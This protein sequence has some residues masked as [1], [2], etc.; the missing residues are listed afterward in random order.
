M[1]IANPIYDVVFKYLMEDSKLAKLLISSIIQQDIEIIDFK[2]REFSTEIE[3]GRIS[4][5]KPN[6]SKNDLFFFTV[7][8]LD[9]SAKIKTADGEK[10][11]IIEIQKAKLATDILCFRGYLGEQYGNKENVFWAT[12]KDKKRKWACEIISIYFLGNSLENIKG[13]PVIKS[14]KTYIDVNTGEEIKQKEY[15]LDSLNHESYTIPIPELKQKRR[16]ELE[17]LLGI[18]D[19]SNRSSD[20]HI[21]NVKEEDFPVKFRE[22]IR[23]LQKAADEPEIRKKMD[24]E[25][26]IIEELAERDRELIEKDAVIDTNLKLLAEETKQKEEAIARENEAKA[27][28]E[29]ERRQ[30]EIIKRYYKGESVESLVLEYD[31]TIEEIKK[32]V[33]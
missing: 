2:P 19:Q 6:Q 30:K 20:D 12:E 7:Y 10:I 22:I 8:R 16:N 21:M 29:D 31:K 13:V 9:F 3:K 33:E 14:P 23:K 24:A 17:Q 5:N 25:D 1:Q 32:I 11:V 28:E 26:E 4:K 27:R 15:F 18:F